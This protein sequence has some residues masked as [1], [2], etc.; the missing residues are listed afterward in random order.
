[1]VG[2]KD[3]GFCFP[4]VK[5]CFIILSRINLWHSN[6]DDRNERLTLLRMLELMELAFLQMCPWGWIHEREIHRWLLMHRNYFWHRKSLIVNSWRLTEHSG[7]YQ[8]IFSLTYYIPLEFCFWLLL[9]FIEKLKKISSFRESTRKNPANKQ[10]QNSWILPAFSTGEALLC[11]W[12]WFSNKFEV[13]F[14]LWVQEVLKRKWITR[15]KCLVSLASLFENQKLCFTLRW[16]PRGY[17][18]SLN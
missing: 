15:L 11:L 10:W 6:N 13:Y 7:R 3:T 5:K 1:M 14:S 12:Y 2:D 17:P 9:Y 8:W 18:F 16:N 4:K